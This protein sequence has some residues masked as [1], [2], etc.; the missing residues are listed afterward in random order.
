MGIDNAA[1]IVFVGMEGVLLG[2]YHFVELF[3]LTEADLLRRAARQ[4]HLGQIRNLEGGD[5]RDKVWPPLTSDSA[6][7][8]SCP[9]V[10]S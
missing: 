1:S 8:T 2:D 6:L 3:P 10:P 4:D 9:P 7:T 5:L